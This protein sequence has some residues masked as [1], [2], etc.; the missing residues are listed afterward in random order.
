MLRLDPAFRQGSAD[1]ALGR[2][3][4]KVPR[5]FGGSNAKAEEHLKASLKYDPDSTVTHF[6]LAE[7]QGHGRMAE[8]R[9]DNQKVLDAP[10]D[11][12]WAPEDRD[13]KDK[14]RR[15]L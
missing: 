1:R 5:L 8:A 2:W 12:G 3:Y 15:L 7:L 11:P 9:A 14:A 4:H 10:V 13:F 6:F